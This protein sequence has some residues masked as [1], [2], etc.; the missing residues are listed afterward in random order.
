MSNE[1]ARQTNEAMRRQ[2]LDAQHRELIAT[3]N[4]LIDRLEAL[5]AKLDAERNEKREVTP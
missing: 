4:K 3:I 5:N 1:G 2:A